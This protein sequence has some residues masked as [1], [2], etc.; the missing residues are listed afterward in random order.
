MAG[1]DSAEEGKVAVFQSRGATGKYIAP[2]L[3][4]GSSPQPFTATKGTLEDLKRRF[5]SV[6]APG[7]I[8][9]RHL[10]FVLARDKVPFG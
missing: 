5:Y 7:N 1:I 9:G 2:G 8:T 4:W 10:Y 3:C 6:L